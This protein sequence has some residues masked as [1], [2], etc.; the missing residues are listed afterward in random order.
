MKTRPP[1]DKR[2]NLDKEIDS[3]LEQMSVLEAN[4]DQYKAMRENLSAL[5]EARALIKPSGP[6]ADA[7]LTVAGSLMGI[8][9]M[10]GYE[11]THVITSKAIGFVLKPRV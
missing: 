6:S 8:V 5:C 7:I 9:L 4:T 1:K 11:Q 10:L 2:T 3:V